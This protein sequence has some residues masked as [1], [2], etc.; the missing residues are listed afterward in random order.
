MWRLACFAVCGKSYKLF[1][2]VIA[3]WAKVFRTFYSVHHYRQY[4]GTE[5]LGPSLYNITI[6]GLSEHPF[7][8]PSQ[9]PI[10]RRKVQPECKPPWTGFLFFAASDSISPW[11]RWESFP[12]VIYDSSKNPETYEYPAWYLP[13]SLLGRHHLT[14]GKRQLLLPLWVMNRRSSYMLIYMK[15]ARYWWRKPLPGWPPDGKY[16]KIR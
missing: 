9:Y 6:S 11:D 2:E 7:L 14:I 13:S 3:D 1:R 15:A 10:F 5:P 12:G 16:G 8:R 4:H